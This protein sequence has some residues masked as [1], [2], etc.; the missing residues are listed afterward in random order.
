MAACL[1]Y[2]SSVLATTS[3]IDDDMTIQEN[4][5]K[6]YSYVITYDKDM[7]SRASSDA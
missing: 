2:S 1:L 3:N 6:N 7:S 4:S 5:K